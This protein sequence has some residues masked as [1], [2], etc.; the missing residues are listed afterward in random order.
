M[1]QLDDA[2]G[3]LLAALLRMDDREVRS[4]LAQEHDPSA[5]VDCLESL[6]VPALERLG[7]GWEAGR[8]AL[9]QIYVA[10]RLCEKAVQDILPPAVQARPGQ[11]KMAIAVIED[12][13]ALGK[14]MVLSCLRASGFS[15]LDYGHGCKAENLV[16]QVMA[17]QVEV[18]F[19][20]CLMLASAMRVAEVADGLRKAGC[21]TAVVVGGAPFRF[22]DQLFAQV[23]ARAM[24]RTAAEA[25]GIAE[26]LMGER[27]WA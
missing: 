2:V 18:I 11:P 1:T 7:Q 10:G 14:R 25:V 15:L 24:G 13:H 9:S 4:L 6:V 12:H 26:A 8:V 19:L 21:K 5:G 23:G 27:P 3:K 20:S 22:D 17:D 16:R